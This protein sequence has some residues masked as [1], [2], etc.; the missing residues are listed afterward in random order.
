[1]AV[2]IDMARQGYAQQ[3]RGGVGKQLGAVPISAGEIEVRVWGPSV[4]SLAVD[5]VGGRHELERDGEYWEARV[6]AQP[7]DEYLFVVDERRTYP[8]PCSRSQPD[9]VL[10]PSQVV[11]TG[12]FEWTDAAWQGVPLDDLVIYELHVGTFSEDGTF[13]GVIPRLRGLRELGIT[14]IEL[15]PVATFPGQRGWGYD[16]LYIYAPHPAYGGPAGLARLV[17]AAH[18]EG[19]AVL[20][21][22]VYNHVGPGNEAL[23]AF[24]PYFTSKHHT[25]WGDALDYEQRGVREWALQNAELWT[26]DY[27]VDGLRLDA[28][29]A[30]FDDSPKHVCAELKE[31]VGDSLVISEMEV[32]DWRPIEEWGHDA[33]WADRTHHELH[34]LLTGEQDGYYAGYGSLRRLAD[35]L[36]GHS[37]TG[38]HDPRR[39]VVCAQNHDQVGN[40]AA[41]DRL[42]PDALR[43]AAAVTLFS[44]CTPLLFMGEEYLEPHPFQFFTDHIDPA[45]AEATRE[46]RRKEFEGFASF[47]GEDVPDPQDVETFLRSKLA[48]REPDPLYR[49]LLALRRELPREL[50]TDVDEEAKVLRMRRGGV[51]LVADF[52]AKRVEVRR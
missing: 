17:D 52:A 45:I 20:L 21:D 44:P 2:M 16:G 35:D 49:E 9:G 32:D 13:D 10:G 22:V 46:G 12:A 4:Q 30:I 39:L 5:I 50:E 14:A 41:G 18:A 33:Q 7:G 43:V 11:D 27:H 28:V 23:R 42:P 47:S 48:P 37:P 6:P 8:D 15:M 25:F 51:E 38:H 24:G 36:K 3:V 29:H 26:R 19:L 1:M 31:R 40:R 34:A